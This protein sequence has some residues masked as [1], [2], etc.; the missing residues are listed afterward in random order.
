VI[1]LRVVDPSSQAYTTGLI[2][3]TRV[4]PSDIT[5]ALT[6]LDECARVEA[7]LDRMPIVRTVVGHPASAIAKV[8]LE[9]GV[10]LIAMATHGRSGLLRLV[11]GSVANVTVQEANVP[12]VLTKLTEV[13]NADVQNGVLLAS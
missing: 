5:S 2:G 7:W 10:D 11:L 4:P 13:E 6:Y 1:L 8:A 9:L 3:D 12:V